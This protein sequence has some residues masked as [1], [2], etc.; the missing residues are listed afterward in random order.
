MTRNGIIEAEIDRKKSLTKYEVVETQQ[1]IKY[2]YLNLVRLYPETGRRHQLRIHLSS[3]GNPILGD[4]TYGI[5]GSVL[6]GKGLYLCASA[7]RFE[8]PITKEIISLELDLPAKFDK[9]FPNK[10]S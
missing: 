1:S 5:E 2:Q 7:L 9:I 6:R 4:T 10:V 3:I 8:H